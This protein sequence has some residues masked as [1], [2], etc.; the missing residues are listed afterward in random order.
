MSRFANTTVRVYNDAFTCSASFKRSL[1]CVNL[2]EGL[3]WHDGLRQSFYFIISARYERSRPRRSFC[4][5]P[6]VRWR[7]WLAHDMADIHDHIEIVNAYRKAK[8]RACTE[9]ID[10]TEEDPDRQEAIIDLT[11]EEEDYG[12][13]KGVGSAEDPFVLND[14]EE[15]VLVSPV[16]PNVNAP[17]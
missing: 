10:L 7:N 1:T 8:A 14:E 15:F 6:L 11:D 12:V 16:V 2:E 13:W 3:Y 4:G 9:Y 5:M 17:A